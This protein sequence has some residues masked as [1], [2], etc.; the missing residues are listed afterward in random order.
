MGLGRLGWGGQDAG[1]GQAAAGQARGSARVTTVPCQ[2]VSSRAGSRR[3]GAG[4]GC[5][6]AGW[7]QGGQAGH[8][9]ASGQRHSWGC[10]RRP[11]VTTPFASTGWII[12][13]TWPTESRG[14]SAPAPL[15]P[16]PHC[17]SLDSCPS[18][19]PPH[20]HHQDRQLSCASAPCPGV[21]CP[22]RELGATEPSEC[23]ERATTELGPGRGCPGGPAPA[24]GRVN[25]V[26]WSHPCPLVPTLSLSCICQ[27]LMVFAEGH[28]IPPFYPIVQDG[29]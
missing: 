17:P 5:W 26:A 21:A 2:A 6:P 16:A 12:C 3:V 1:T 7:G 24:Q 22:F 9:P 29:P 11:P 14:N 23:L 28:R 10:A 20:R 8:R 13:S 25:H 27:L 15:P 18:G 19:P 4:L